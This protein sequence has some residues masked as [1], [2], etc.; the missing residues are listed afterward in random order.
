M[1]QLL[2]NETPLSTSMNDT[3]MNYAR[4]GGNIMRVI[5]MHWLTFDPLVQLL[6]YLVISLLLFSNCEM[7]KEMIMNT[8]RW[9]IFE[10]IK[11]IS[12]N[13]SKIEFVPTEIKLLALV[14][15]SKETEGKQ[16]RPG[17][18]CISDSA[19]VLTY[20]LESGE[21]PF[22]FFNLCFYLSLALYCVGSLKPEEALIYLYDGSMVKL[23]EIGSIQ[24]MSS[25]W[26]F[27]L[28]LAKTTQ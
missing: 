6:E 27:Q 17:I 5:A 13:E 15:D 28:L 23:S 12:A 11:V 24:V 26:C 22:S 20:S 3:S 16:I 10:G 4:T 9:H 21:S 7:K 1:P 14:P 25:L 2:Q 19:H 18:Y 8:L